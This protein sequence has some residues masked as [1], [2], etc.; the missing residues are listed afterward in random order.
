VTTTK[1]AAKALRNGAERMITL[2]RKAAWPPPPGHGL[3]IFDKAAG[4]SLFDKAQDALRRA[5]G[6]LH[7]DHSHG[8]PSRHNARWPSSAGRSA[9]RRILPLASNTRSSAFCG[10]GSAKTAQSS[11]QATVSWP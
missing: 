6:W 3:N 1:R 5:P 4:H 11:V 2:A 8:A 9:L 10:V 7:P